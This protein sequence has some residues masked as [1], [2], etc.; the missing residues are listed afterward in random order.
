M[1][2]GLDLMLVVSLEGEKQSH[3]QRSQEEGED[4]QQAQGQQREEERGE[5]G[6]K[7]ISSEKRPSWPRV[8][9]GEE[10]EG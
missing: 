4:K 7:G 6:F 3:K 9:M 8:R 1:F 2:T 5:R 10:K